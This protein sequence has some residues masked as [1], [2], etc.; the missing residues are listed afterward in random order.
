ME[1][2]ERDQDIL[3]TLTL[4]V[5]ILSIDQLAR[6]WWPD[7]ANARRAA[8][9]RLDQLEAAHLVGRRSV[10]A[11]PMLSLEAPV[12]VWQPGAEAPE[13]EAVSHELRSRWTEAP[14]ATTVY[15][16][17]RRT[18]NQYGGTGPAKLPPLGQETH[19]LHVGELYIRLRAQD[20]HAASAW[21]GEEHYRAERRGEK[22][23]D[24]MLVGPEGPY[25]VVEF[26]GAYDAEH[27]DSFHR[28]CSRRG[29]PYELW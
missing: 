12:F 22:R 25:L 26:A 21:V 7:S 6:A 28:D 11:R 19:D 14:R 17:T 10:L 15:L 29:L 1:R 9:R 2:T 3:R 27:V 18:L 20:R 5:R 24:A 16:A 4:R 8:R 13:P 23:P